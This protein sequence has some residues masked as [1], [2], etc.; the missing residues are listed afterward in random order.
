MPWFCAWVF[1]EGKNISLTTPSLYLYYFLPRKCYFRPLYWNHSLL[2]ANQINNIF[3]GVMH[4]LKSQCTA[5]L[6]EIIC[7]TIHITFQYQ[8]LFK[9]TF[10][11]G[12]RPMIFFYRIIKV[13]LKF[14]K[15]LQH[16]TIWIRFCTI[17]GD[18][19]IALM[20][21]LSH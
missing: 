1:Q 11:H 20:V 14:N 19:L 4:F 5:K 9:E 16:F 10:V 13:F 3:T 7:L 12:N 15:V 21:P 18:V 2:M 17:T 8:I 6:L